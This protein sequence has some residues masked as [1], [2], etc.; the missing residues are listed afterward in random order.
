M[1]KIWP[2]SIFEKTFFP[3]ENTGNMLEIAVCFSHKNIIDIAFSFVRSFVLSLSGRS[4]Y[5]K[6]FRNGPTKFQCSVCMTPYKKDDV[7]MN[8]WD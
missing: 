8:P 2:S 5:F 4:N 3:A 7:S 1:H 6:F